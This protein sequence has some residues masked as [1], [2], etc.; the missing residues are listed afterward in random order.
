MAAVCCL[1]AAASPWVVFLSTALLSETLFAALCTACL[2]LLRRLEREDGAPQL[3]ACGAAL[4]AGAAFLTRAAGIALI[5]AGLL[6]LFTPGRRVQ[7]PIFL[8]I[9]FGVCAP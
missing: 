2:I 9:C 1:L 8:L 5:V 3:T 6:M 7:T 4:L